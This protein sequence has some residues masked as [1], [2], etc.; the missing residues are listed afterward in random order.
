MVDIRST[1]G[2]CL[3]FLRKHDKHVRLTSHT[4]GNVPLMMEVIEP[5]QF[6]FRPLRREFEYYEQR[7]F[8]NGTDLFRVPI[9]DHCRKG[10][11]ESKLHALT[12]ITG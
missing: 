2:G 7:G 9:D 8:E 5:V 11:K 10:S 4:L 12:D 1:N 6:I 3:P